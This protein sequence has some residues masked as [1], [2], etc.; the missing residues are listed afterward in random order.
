MDYLYCKKIAVE[1][2]IKSASKWFKFCKENKKLELPFHPERKF[3]EWVSW[4]D[5]LDKKNLRKYKT[6]DE[7][8]DTINSNSSYILGL[9]AADGHVRKN[10][11][12]I[13]Q[14]KKD[15]YL[16]EKIL[17]IMNSENKLNVHNS[18]NLYFNI[19]SE[20]IV[21]DI[22]K[23]FK[24]SIGKKTYELCFPEIDEK[25]LPDF[26]RGYFDGDGCITYQKKEKCY[27]SSIVSAS[28]NLI[29]G[30][31]NILKKDNEF[32]GRLKEKNGIFQLIMGVNDTR[33]F[34]KYIYDNISDN[35]LYLKRKK[36]KFDLAGDIK[37][38]SFN[39]KFLSYQESKIYIKNLGIK[40]YRAWR[41][42]K[43]ENKI[44]NI[45]SDVSK[46][47]E[48]LCWSDFIS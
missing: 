15:K 30:V 23:I 17:H 33:R 39:K 37:I 34:G 13:T 28:E 47:K 12:S 25:Y 22:R 48:Y 29:S 38:A 27:V 24:N 19:Y 21:S 44:E 14:S 1:Y 3:K 40:T 5:F 2:D 26:I 46:Y 10:Q 9:W 16:L 45:P 8:F 7:L 4:F 6:N 41:N 32:N 43:K 20:K 18:D 35:G 11:F 31:Y 42:F 36:E